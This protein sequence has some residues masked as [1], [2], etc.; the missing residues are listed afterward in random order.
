MKCFKMLEM[1]GILPRNGTIETTESLDV[2]SD[3]PI[4][5]PDGHI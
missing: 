1:I 5:S 2:T 3:F 4:E